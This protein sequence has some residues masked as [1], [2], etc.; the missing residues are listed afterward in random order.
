MESAFH[1]VHLDFDCRL[2]T[3]VQLYEDNAKQIKFSSPLEIALRKAAWV[4]LQSLVHRGLFRRSTKLTLQLPEYSCT[5]QLGG[6]AVQH[7]L[8]HINFVGWC[9]PCA[10][11]KGSSVIY[12]WLYLINIFYLFVAQ[13]SKLIA[14]LCIIVNSHYNHSCQFYANHH[15]WAWIYDILACCC[16]KSYKWSSCFSIYLQAQLLLLTI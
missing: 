4:F 14:S 15:V 12:L 5:A 2:S 13:L 6:W 11:H 10:M 9:V 8:T 3:Q 7:D 16:C 1:K